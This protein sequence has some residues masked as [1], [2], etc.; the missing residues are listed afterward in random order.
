MNF[1]KTTLALAMAGIVA[2]PMMAQAE[3]GFY[4]S[5]RQG[6]Q[7]SS[8]DAP[9][10]DTSL[11]ITNK[12]SRMGYGGET[13]LGNG[14]TGFG[15]YEFGVN[16]S[17]DAAT[18][19]RRKAY[20]GVKGDFGSVLMGQTYHTFY[21]HVNGPVDIANWNSGFYSTG[22]TDQA[23]TYSNEFGPVSVGVT[24]YARSDDNPN[25]TDAVAATAAT[26]TA[27]ETLGSDAVAASGDTGID[28]TEI[29]ASFN[30]G[31][32]KIGLGV[33]S[34]SNKVGVDPEDTTGIALSGNIGDVYLGV[35]MQSQDKVKDTT[36]ISAS[37]GQGYVIYAVADM[38]GAATEGDGP[39]S[40]TLGYSIPVGSQTSAWLEYTTHDTDTTVANAA[41]TSQ[42]EAILKYS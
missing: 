5:V 19:S 17:G 21:S 32:V 7:S 16:T 24:A 30:A 26:A 41:D 8:N 23:I 34:E 36:E 14:M 2:A 28:G 15:K 37:Y 40:M 6:I 4:G 27:V 12:G 13:D 42:I 18:I 10:S 33:K 35:S 39:S 38:E 1:K 22:R 11:K 9:G 25:G 31:P 3:S 29:A 20:V